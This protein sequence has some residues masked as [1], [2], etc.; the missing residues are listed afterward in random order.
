MTDDK[1]DAVLTDYGFTLTVAGRPGLYRFSCSCGYEAAMIASRNPEFAL[2]IATAHLNTHK[3]I[4]DT[5]PF[6][7][8]S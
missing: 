8:V 5:D 7:G 4:E 6:E 2:K 3:P 1:L